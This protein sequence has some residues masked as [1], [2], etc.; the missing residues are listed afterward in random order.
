M[1]GLALP[2]GRHAHER[3]QALIYSRIREN[4]LNP[5]GTDFTR[6]RTSRRSCRRAPKLA[7]ASTFFDLP[8]D[9]SS[10][11]KPLAT[12]LSTWHFIELGWVKFRAGD[13]AP[14]PARRRGDWQRLHHRQAGEHRRDPDGARELG[15]AAAPARL[16]S[17]RARLRQRDA[18]LPE[19]APQ[20]P[21][22]AGFFSVEGF[23]S[24]F[25][26]SPDPRRP[27]RPPSSPPSP[28]RSRSCRSPTPCSGS[29]SGR[30]RSRGARRRRRRTSRAPARSSTGSARTCAP[31][32]SDIRRSAR[33]QKATGA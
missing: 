9:G 24:V 23:A 21:P 16:G 4:Q 10:L 11:M 17:L 25:G 5:A 32:G 29:Q 6:G 13:V 33:A 26:A 15:A 7:S 22:A 8:F 3:R 12:D 28:C 2:P 1:E 19:V 18:V 31:R 30:G 20:S 14:L 27:P